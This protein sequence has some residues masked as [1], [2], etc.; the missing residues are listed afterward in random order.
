[1]HQHRGGAKLD[2]QRVDLRSPLAVE[3][4]A[5]AD[6]EGARSEIADERLL[7]DGHARARS[8]DHCTAGNAE[9]GGGERAAVGDGECSA[10]DDSRRP[11][12]SEPPL[13]VSAG[14]EQLKQSVRPPMVPILPPKLA[15]VSVSEAALS[16]SSEP[17]PE[18]LPENVV[19]PLPTMLSR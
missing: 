3:H 2:K 17:A 1:G 11:T 12:V 8:G 7:G 6:G 16:S 9:I 10:L 19:A 5:V 13:I 14:A 18:N 15:P 4:T